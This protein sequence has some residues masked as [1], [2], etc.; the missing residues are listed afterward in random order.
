MTTHRMGMTYEPKIEGV[1]NGTI[2]QT[3]R[4]LNPKHPFKLGDRL[5]IHGWEG[6]PYRSKWSWRMD[7]TVK[8]LDKLEVD[9]EAWTLWDHEDLMAEG[10]CTALHI[11]DQEHPRMVV[12]ALADGIYP[13]TSQGVKK[14]L[15][16]FHGPFPRDDVIEFQVIRW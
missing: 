3:I 11:W 16:A 2:R 4:K 5:L 15:E 13:P 9:S 1:R 10:W 6:R 12:I 14:V 8:E 7:E